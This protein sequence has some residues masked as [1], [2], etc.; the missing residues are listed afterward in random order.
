MNYLI[1]QERRKNFILVIVLC[2][3]IYPLVPTISYC[4][5]IWYLGFG[6]T[7]D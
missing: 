6:R 4:I 1:V 3:T 7:G 2:L 5:N